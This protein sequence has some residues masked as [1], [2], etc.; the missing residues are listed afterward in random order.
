MRNALLCKMVDNL[1]YWLA[2]KESKHTVTD[3]MLFRERYQGKEMAV[4]MSP[5]K[6]R[7]GAKIDEKLLTQ[8]FLASAKTEKAN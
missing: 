3:F 5:V 1:H 6:E 8:L 4:P 2:G 7:K